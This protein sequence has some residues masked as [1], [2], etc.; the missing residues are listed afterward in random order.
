MD[1]RQV[2]VVG[3]P[4]F[5]PEYQS[6][7]ASGADL[8]ARLDSDIVLRPGQ[9]TLVPTGITL[10]IPA[11]VEGQVR[12]RSGLAARHGVTVLNAPGTVDSD[13]RGEVQVILVNLGSEDFTI[14]PGDRVAQIVF[15]PVERV[16]FR[17]RERLSE[18]ERGDGGFGSTGT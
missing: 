8:R 15:S 14:H 16:V 7:G 6:A 12:P 9:R 2:P 17:S 4:R 11:G 10:E 13:Y 1:G 5:L 3:D 18:S